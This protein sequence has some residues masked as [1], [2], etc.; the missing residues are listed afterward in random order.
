MI[1]GLLGIL[2]VALLMFAIIGSKSKPPIGRRSSL[3]KTLVRERWQTIQS[4]TKQGG[5]GL[6]N[7]VS[8]ADKLLD[9]VLKAQGY[10]GQT[11]AERLKRAE[12]KLSDKEA[13]WQA[14]KLRNALAHEVKFDLVASHAKEALEG[15]E[16]GLRDLGAL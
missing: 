14:H 9:Y 16:T 1:W 3:D 5:N 8:E 10:A 13:V 11:L 4:L 7:A 15:F 12:S 2:A 6:K